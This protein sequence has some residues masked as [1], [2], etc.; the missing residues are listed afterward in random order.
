MILLQCPGCLNHWRMDPSEMSSEILAQC[1]NCHARWRIKRKPRKIR[2]AVVADSKSSFREFIVKHLSNIGFYVRTVEDGDGLM[3]AVSEQPDLV[4]AN[5]FLPGKL[6]VEVCQWM[7]ENSDLHHIPFI[8]IGALFR[9]ERYRGPA[10]SLYGADD[11]IEEGITPEEFAGIVRRLTGFGMTAAGPQTSP[12]EE[13]IRR[14]LRLLISEIQ[15]NG[16]DGKGLRSHLKKMVSSI[17]QDLP[18]AD[19]LLVKKIASD[20]ITG[21][22][23]A[24]DQH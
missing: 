11:Y 21:L 15:S 3:D 16:M 17:T 9:V 12:V 4:V 23:G 7:K 6:G 19:P 5:V 22:E 2:K 10:H 24:H 1:P 20:Y 13:H 14:K 8:L 18:E